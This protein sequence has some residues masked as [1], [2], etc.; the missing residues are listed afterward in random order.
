MS[1]AICG[2]GVSMNAKCPECFALV[3][4]RTNVVADRRSIKNG[5]VIYYKARKPRA[6]ARKR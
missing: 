4:E 6:K 2:H 5:N 1:I 3:L